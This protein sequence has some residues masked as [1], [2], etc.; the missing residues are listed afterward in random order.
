MLDTS[1]PFTR[2]QALAAGIG[3]SA[4]RSRAFRRL[5]TGVF[6]GADA[7]VTPRLRALAA[8]LTF[9]EDAWVSHASAARVYGAPIPVL[10]EEHVSV[11]RRRDRRDRAGV[12]CHLGRAP[13]VRIVDGA[14]VSDYPQ[15]FVELASQLTLVDLVIVGDFLV[16]QRKIAVAALRAFCERQSGAGVRLARRAADFVRAGVDS[17]METRLRM[18]IVLAG[19]PEPVV[20]LEVRSA[21]GWL[22]RKYD[23][24]WPAQRIAIE[25][26]GRLHVERETQWQ[27]DLERREAS[28]DDGWRTL[29]MTSRDVFRTPEDALERIWRLARLRKVPGTPSRLKDDWRQHFRSSAAA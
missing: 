4:L 9:A 26:D 12:V 21:D 6:V 22:L 19:L 10:P 23:L 17:P 13:V 15:L 18:L 14:R 29:V 1:R 5:F 25:Y 27:K 24:S 28:D 16:R 20:N 11:L 3:V 8:R 7:T 2:Q